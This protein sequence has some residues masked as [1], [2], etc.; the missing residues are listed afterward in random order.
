MIHQKFFLEKSTLL[1]NTYGHVGST[2]FR[3]WVSSFFCPVAQ[4]ALRHRVA[5]HARS[6]THKCSDLRRNHACAHR[7]CTSLQLL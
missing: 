3:F 5:M 7:M 6:G 4:Q 1:T 2:D